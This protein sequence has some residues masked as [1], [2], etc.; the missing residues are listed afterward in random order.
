MF[1]LGG[2]DKE[3][4]KENMEEIKD[5]VNSQEQGGS[6]SPQ[7]LMDDSQ[8]SVTEPQ[9]DSPDRQTPDLNQQSDNQMNPEP[10]M[11]NDL[12]SKSQD[13]MNQDLNNL[14]DAINNQSQ[15][16]QETENEPDLGQ[17]PRNNNFD[18]SRGLNDNSSSS[19]DSTSRDSDSSSL[20]G[21]KSNSDRPDIS[22]QPSPDGDSSETLF[23]EVDEFNRVKEMV[24]EMKYLSREMNDLMENLEG[25]VEEDRRIESEAQDV[26]DEFS[27]RREHIES[28]IN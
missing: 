14:Q 26:I 28:S 23:L 10:D 9:E 25:G 12:P 3:K 17:S 1:N 6:P 13:S 8:D 4:L 27:Q 15:N 2:N 16:N 19:Q 5:L 24:D 20:S 18:S 11:N 7:E 22:D 21:I